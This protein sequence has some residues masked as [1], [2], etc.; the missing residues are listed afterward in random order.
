M[1]FKL[2][3]IYA[4]AILLIPIIFFEI[5]SHFFSQKSYELDYEKLWENY[6]TEE[7]D[8][9]LSS[10]H[11]RTG[12]NCMEKIIPTWHHK[13]G[14]QDKKI[15]F[16]CL[17]KHFT[18]KTLNIAFFGGSVM[19][20]TYYKNYLTSIDWQV[21]KDQENIH[22]IN[23]AQSGSRLS[24]EFSSFIIM[25]K[26]T[27]PDIAIFLDGANEFNSIKYN[28]GK[29]DEDFY[30][31]VWAKKRIEDP[32][33]IYLDKM[34]ESS[35]TAKAILIN[36]FGYKPNNLIENHNIEDSKI[37]ETAN[38]YLHY[39]EIIES[40]CKN[41]NIKCLFFLQ[42]IIYTTSE[43]VDELTINIEK[44]FLGYYPNNKKIYK[45]GYKEILKDKNL[46][47]LSDII[48][49]NKY[50]FIDEMHLTKVGSKLIAEEM[51]KS[52]NSN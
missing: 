20:S 18:N 16:E 37:L 26:Y 12:K 31:T 6:T 14:F 39:K 33:L 40:I 29:P 28:N 7:L 47:D 4:I 1:S 46:I 41:Q 24:N 8:K 34:I 5:F 13:I 11:S 17:K 15:N 45:L 42:P 10:F 44:K 19:E 27:K 23:F 3:I 38:D 36:L 9:N 48:S 51:K 22:S 50:A 49:N 30:W 32:F 52:M 43:I 35:A 2:K 25:L 21:I